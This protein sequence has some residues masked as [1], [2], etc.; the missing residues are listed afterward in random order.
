MS[1]FKTGFLSFFTHMV[2]TDSDIRFLGLMTAFFV[3][4]AVA[5]ALLCGARY[6]WWRLR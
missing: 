2:P 1:E 4:V 3:A 5:F 6:L